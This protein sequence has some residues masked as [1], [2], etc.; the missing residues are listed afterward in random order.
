MLNSR[1]IAYGAFG[2]FFLGLV[3]A[4]SPAQTKGPI[5]ADLA[6]TTKAADIVPQAQLGD[7][8][9]PLKYTLDF[10]IDPREDGFTGLT[11]IDID[12]KKPTQ[13]IWLHGKNLKITNAVA[14]APDGRKIS[15]SYSQVPISEAPSGIAYLQFLEPVGPGQFTLRL[16][17]S[18][19]YNTALNAAYKVV[20][21][22]GDQTDNYIITQ[23]QAIGAR[24]AFPGFDEPRFKVP[25]DVSIS[26]PSMDVVY[27]NTPEISQNS[28]DEG[29]TKHVF[30]TT[31]PL[32]TYLI[33]YGV[34]PWDVV[35]FDPLPP[36]AMRDHE[37][38]LRGLAARNSG[39]KMQYAL[40]NT[41]GIMEVME[42]YF[43]SPYPYKK[44]D[45]IAAPEYAFGAMENP[46]A[47]VF[48]EYLLLMNDK[49]SP[50]QKRAYAYVNAHELA[51]QWFG[52]LVTP[53]WWE[54]IWLN[55]SFATWMG[56]KTVDTWA[57]HYKFDRETQKGAL[58][59]MGT[60]SLKSTRKIREPLLRTENVMNQFDSITYQK[61]GGVLAMFESYL[62]AE[63]FQKGVRL[64]MQRF[65]DKVATADD[66]FQSLADGSGNAQITSAMKSFVDQR[67]V[68]LVR[69]TLSCND[70]E[71]ILEQ[72]RYAPLGSSINR[73]QTWQIPVCA[74]YGTEQGSAKTCTLMTEQTTTLKLETK[75]CP[76]W[77][78]LNADGSGYYR[79][80][81]DKQAW[82]GLL[83]NVDQL[84]TKE[85]L[86]VVDSLISSFNASELD[87][88][89]YLNGL[90]AFAANPEA[91][92]VS[93]A[94]N[95]LGTL[96][97]RLLPKASRKDLARFTRALYAERYAQIKNS[98]LMAD[99]LLAPTLVTRLIN[100]GMD[101]KIS[102]EFSAAGAKYLGLNGPA[103][104][105][106]LKPSMLSIGLSQVF[107]DQGVVALPALLDLIES[108]S[109]A[110][111]GSASG[112]L[113]ATNDPKLALQI[114]EAA[115]DPKGVFTGRQATGLIYGLLYNP[116]TSLQTWKWIN[117]NFEQLLE[118]RI[119]D[120]RRAGTPRMGG[121]FCSTEGANEMKAFF[122]S[123]AELI[124][125]YE[126]ALDQT[127]ERIDLCVAAKSAQGEKLAEAL[128][129]RP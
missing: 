84:N 123:K 80:T 115:L 128:A 96:R 81:M 79:F 124:P 78:T 71:I 59:T 87:A 129:A 12:I 64:H 68:P 91:D 8:I 118:T 51:H 46:G 13:K 22:T 83:Q 111:K 11:L 27:A 100:Y 14:I 60:D 70:N 36:T 126:Q 97:G 34:G 127:L 4:C 107:K 98:E 101:Q 103:D 54:D 24:E 25:F 20:R 37:V 56:N 18:A 49:S 63:N 106:A 117:S 7:N 89:T 122:E 21:K 55:E 23:F 93:A 35:E 45:L 69:G 82:A 108:G 116:A 10:K 121:F 119:A 62:G 109:P 90:A 9:T 105:T 120:V 39:D 77:V 58:R 92:V 113:S 65:E 48:T 31:R 3:S 44:L 1:L 94:G 17:Y 75:T 15:A 125:G 26:A 6:T 61:G 52:D 76:S 16:P 47:I 102:A 66:F 88:K 99:E 33:A 114:L 104:K 50:R 2:L 95:T 86:S 43:G 57:P 29:W 30:A 5:S 19:P 72:S 110:E 38:P 53:V 42:D 41:A 112:A 28:S 32:P 85:A 74:R 73:N 40:K 67:G